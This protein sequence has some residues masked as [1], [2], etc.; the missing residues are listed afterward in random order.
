MKSDT[1]NWLGRLALEYA[2]HTIQ[3]TGRLGIPNGGALDLAAL[4]PAQPQ[5]PDQALQ[6]AVAVVRVH[7]AVPHGACSLTGRFAALCK[8]ARPRKLVDVQRQALSDLESAVELRLGEKRADQ[9]ENL[10]GSA[11]FLDLA[12]QFLG[13][14]CLADCYPGA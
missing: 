7:A 5:A 3:R 14:L 11:Q 1:H 2:V 12:L 6:R 13:A 9:L 4:D 10:V 8:S